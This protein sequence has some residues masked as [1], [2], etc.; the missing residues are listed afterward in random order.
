MHVL[1]ERGKS[2]CLFSVAKYVH[3]AFDSAHAARNT[4]SNIS[5]LPNLRRSIEHAMRER[6]FIFR[7]SLHAWLNNAL[8]KK[9]G[10]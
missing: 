8:V 10:A 1:E 9:G 7:Q 5:L 3:F 4:M 2:S 6:R